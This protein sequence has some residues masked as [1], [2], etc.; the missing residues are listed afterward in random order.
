MDINIVKMS[1]LTDNLHFS[2]ILDI[3]DFTSELSTLNIILEYIL[4]VILYLYYNSST[5][6]DET[7]YFINIIS[8]I[9]N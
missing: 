2:R 5:S 6:K 3:E 1:K 8:F 7:I 9:Y 4:V